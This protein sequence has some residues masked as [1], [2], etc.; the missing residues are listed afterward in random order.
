[1]TFKFKVRTQIIHAKSRAYYFSLAYSCKKYKVPKSILSNMKAFVFG[2]GGGGDILSALLPYVYYKRLGYE[3]KLGAVVWERYVEDPL[4]GP[5]CKEDLVNFEEINDYVYKVRSNSYAIRGDLKV[6]PQ[7]M[8]VLK[9]VNDYGFAICNKGGDIGMSEALNDL[10]DKEKFDLVIGVD[11]GGDVLA[12]GGE[13]GLGSPLID[14]ISL[15][16]LVSLKVKSILGIIGA[17][18]DGELDYEYILRRISEVAKIGGLLDSK[19]IDNDVAN[20]MGEA[21]KIVNTE[22]SRIPFEAFHGLYGEVKIRN[23]TRKVYVNPV[24]SVMF[25]LDPKK[26]AQI[27]GIYKIVAGSRSLDEANEKFHRYGIYTEYDF[28]KDLFEKFGFN[29][30]NAT[31]DELQRIR[32]EGISRVKS[33]N[34]FNS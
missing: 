26:L 15:A 12:N 10:I 30:R 1:M 34:V 23:G 4:P 11:A 8:R 6:V 22:A 3:V 24:S 21:L 29:S 13:K 5:I 14:S 27:S 2:I 32:E 9:V 20:L 18:S 31:Y 25:F 16:S 33:G 19:G 17:G 7:L 28:E